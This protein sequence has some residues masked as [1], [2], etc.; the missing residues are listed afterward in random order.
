M[1]GLTLSLLAA[2]LLAV[3]A[4]AQ[5]PKDSKE[6]VLV[7]PTD[8]RRDLTL[9]KRLSDGS[10][11]HEGAG[12]TY[13]IP[14]DW[15][16][17]PPHRLQRKIDTRIMTVLGIERADRDLVASIYWT[18]LEP[19]RRLSDFVRDAAGPA[20]EFGEEYETLK[21]VY[22]KEK[23]TLP[24]RVKVKDFDVYKINVKGGPD[25]GGKYDGT[26]FVFEVKP[27]EVT[28]LV[29]VRV[30]YPKGE[31]GAAD[32]V[33]DEVVEGFTRYTGEVKGPAVTPE[34]GPP[35]KKID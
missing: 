1:R 17:I 6:E 7:K 33:V 26:L 29:R 31:K 30:S 19:N 16:E 13:T 21:T 11:L 25:R 10:L 22:G 20:G 12:L 27:K 5:D 15:K 4:V 24:A 18:P 9:L 35:P 3:P 28:W 34:L 14:K 32:K 8:D 23:V 2:G